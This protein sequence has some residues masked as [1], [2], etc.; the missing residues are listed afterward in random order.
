MCKVYGYIRVS[1]DKQTEENQ[2]HEISQYCSTNGLNVDEWKSLSISSR[3]SQEKRGLT[4]LLRQFKPTDILIV[5]ELSRLG[6]STSEVIDLVNNILKMDVR[7]IMI[8][9]GLD[10]KANDM[11]SKIMITMFSLF[12]ELER[13]LISSRTK[14]AL[15][16]R[17]AQGKI[18]GRKSTGVFEAKHDL[19]MQSINRGESVRQ[20][21]KNLGFKPTSLQAYLKRI[22]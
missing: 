10:L 4:A 22:K 19:I 11:Q 17:K 14:E 9:Q 15:A 1:T 12:A 2:R 20:T 8:K 18:L 16:M 13:D 7:V 3:K 21:A 5:T 6:R